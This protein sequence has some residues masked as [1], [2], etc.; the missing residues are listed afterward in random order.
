MSDD[1]RELTDAELDFV[2]G[3][4][5]LAYATNR[6]ENLVLEIVVDILKIFESFESK[7][8]NRATLS[9]PTY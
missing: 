3:G 6:R 8:A 2:G 9:R 5:G 7:G 4:A 1:L